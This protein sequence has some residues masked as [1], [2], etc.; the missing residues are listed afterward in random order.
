[1]NV[2]TAP[3]RV[4]HRSERSARHDRP[5][6]FDFVEPDVRRFVDQ[7]FRHADDGRALHV[8]VGDA[9]LPR[10]R[11]RHGSGNRDRH[12]TPGARADHL[13]GFRPNLVEKGHC[14][15]N[16]PLEAI[17]SPGVGDRQTPLDE[18]MSDLEVVA[19]ARAR[20]R[21]PLQIAHARREPTSCRH[22]GARREITRDR[23]PRREGGQRPRVRDELD[24]VRPLGPGRASRDAMSQDGR[25]ARGQGQGILDLGEPR[26]ER[27][28][29]RIDPR[30]GRPIRHLARVTAP[31]AKSSGQARGGIA[32]QRGAQRH[33]DAFLRRNELV[34]RW[35]QHGAGV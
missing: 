23:P 26:A 28:G 11:I 32:G 8:N 33:V 17:V 30:E 16:A 18:H 7:V 34:E 22:G 24:E 27:A 1:V 12:D 25:R 21:K 13:R 35:S 2:H 31:E 10:R 15:S 14:L 9:R 5:E 4:E 6:R 20:A 3:G 29:R 19:S